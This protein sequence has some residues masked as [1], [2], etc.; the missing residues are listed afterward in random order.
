MGIIERFQNPTRGF[1]LGWAWAQLVAN[2]GLVLSGGLVRLTGSG[3]GCPTWPRCTED[4]F[5]PH[6]SLGIHGVI[7]FG[8]RLLTYVLVVIAIGLLVS[9]WRW[10]SSD[11]VD[12]GLSVFLAASVP[13]QG[14]I[15]GIT[16]LTDLNPWIVS[17]HLLWSVAIISGSVILL[18]RLQ[19]SS[20]VPSR[21]HI[22][23]MCTYIAL[24]VAVYFGTIVTGSGPHA[25]DG[26]AARNGL[27]PEL[28]SQL[29][30]DSVFLLIGLTIGSWLA[31]RTAAPRAARVARLLLLVELAQGFIGYVQYFT[32]LPIVLVALH[33]IGAAI[34]A[35]VGTWLVM[36]VRSPRQ[37]TGD[38]T[39]AE[40]G[41]IAK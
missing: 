23:V 39:G 13:F 6:G 35:A 12:K 17:F 27:D 15:G 22:V 7:E 20:G 26:G 31:L 37:A 34:L 21:H 16:V 38:G 29:H 25:G 36:S 14:V 10:A 18:L 4:S 3:L 8:N 19:G 40:R 33:M 41:L 9:V 30:A 28:M 24:W 1:V 11:R 2:A 5:V 32:G